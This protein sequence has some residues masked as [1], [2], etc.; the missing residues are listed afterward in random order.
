MSSGGGTAL[1]SSAVGIAVAD[2]PESSESS[3]N[4]AN[5]RARIGR[6]MRTTPFI[7]KHSSEVSRGR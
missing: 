5:E 6:P 3:R 1:I 2:L 4:Y 7:G